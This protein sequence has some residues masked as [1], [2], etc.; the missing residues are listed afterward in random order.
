M[1]HDT[2][3]VLKKLDF[4]FFDA[5]GGHRAAANALRDVIQSQQSPFQVRPTSEKASS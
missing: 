5:G 2:I 3:E 4:I 1:P